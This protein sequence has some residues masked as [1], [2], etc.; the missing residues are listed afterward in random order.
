MHNGFLGNWIRWRRDVETLIPDELYPSRIGTTDSEAIFLAILGAGIDTV[1]AATK[2][3]GKLSDIV[4]RS[5]PG[6]RFRFTAALSDGRDLY[7][8]RYS[9]NDHANTLYYRESDGGI[10]IVSEPFDHDENWTA[11]PEGHVVVAKA[12]ERARMLPLFQ[13]RRQAA[14]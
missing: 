14:E 13:H 10:V 5:E 8:F 1:A 6:D 7:A 4:T 9:V 2:V 3:L 11:V 12:G